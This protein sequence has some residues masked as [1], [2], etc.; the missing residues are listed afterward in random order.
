[1]ISKKPSRKLQIVLSIDGR[2]RIAVPLQVFFQ[3]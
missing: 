2:I 3:E 1:L